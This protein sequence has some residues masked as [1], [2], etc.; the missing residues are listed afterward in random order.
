MVNYLN[1]KCLPSL[2]C[3]SWKHLML[4]NS[5]QTQWKLCIISISLE[6]LV[7]LLWYQDCWF[8]LSSERVNHSPHVPY[9]IS[10]CSSVSE[11]WIIL[12]YLFVSEPL[13]TL[14][15]EGDASQS[16]VSKLGGCYLG[17]SQYCFVSHAFRIHCVQ[18]YD[19]QNHPIL[20]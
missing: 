2:N 15:G 18:T 14:S 11:P 20:W 17:F 3:I 8:I 16:R 9:L 5:W 19:C 6:W 1:N 10:P 7:L 13:I 4:I 12:C